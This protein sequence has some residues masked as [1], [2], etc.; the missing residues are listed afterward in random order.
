MI[1]FYDKER[2]MEKGAAFTSED[3]AFKLPVFLLI[4]L[5]TSLTGIP[6]LL[7]VAVEE[8]PSIVITVLM[9]VPDRSEYSNH[10]GPVIH[11]VSRPMLA[12]HLTRTCRFAFLDCRP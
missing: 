10:P 8:S 7:L 3:L 6:F 4:G 1:R 2:T 9:E 11:P 5:P 12:I